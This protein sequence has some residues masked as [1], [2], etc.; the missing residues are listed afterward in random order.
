M[1]PRPRFG[2]FRP[3]VGTCARHFVG[4][5]D[6]SLFSNLLSDLP[7]NACRPVLANEPIGLSAGNGIPLAGYVKH[8]RE[9]VGGAVFWRNSI[10]IELI[11]QTL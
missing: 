9:V 7:D 3:D 6:F 10:E 4:G 1:T 11:T 8:L 2:H 5:I